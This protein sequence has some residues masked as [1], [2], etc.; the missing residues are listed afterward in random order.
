MHPM[1]DLS[2]EE[3]AELARAWYRKLDVHAPTPELTALLNPNGL[4]MIFPEATLAGIDKFIDWYE[5][6]IRVFF[7]ETHRVISVDVGKPEGDRYCVKVVVEW[8]ASRWKAPAP[9]SERIEC[10]AYQTWVVTPS[11][12]GGGP[13]IVSY[14]VDE[15]RLHPNSAKL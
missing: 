7:D 13:Q 8:K 6:V 5:G 10:D 12:P 2:N 9:N 15:L 4:E 3:I 11:G 14:K 1:A